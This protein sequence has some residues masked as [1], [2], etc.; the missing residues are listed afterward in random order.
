MRWSFPYIFRFHSLSPEEFKSNHDDAIKW[1]HFPRYWPFVRGI[2]WSPVN[3]LHKGQWRRALMFSLICIW[4]NCWVNNREA[5]D[6]RCY[7]THYDV[8]VMQFFKCVVVNTFMKFFN[9]FASG[10][11]PQD[12]FDDTSISV[13]VIQSVNDQ[14]GTKPNLVAEILA[15]KFGVFF[16]YISNVVKNMFNVGLIIMS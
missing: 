10:W 4:I 7:H 11:M 12:P 5:G 8:I 9:A 6:L 16:C 13:Y 1:K 2:H 15:T 14:S 3:S